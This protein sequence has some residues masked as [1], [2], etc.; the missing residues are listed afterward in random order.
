MAL[1]LHGKFDRSGVFEC[2]CH[3]PSQAVT[4]A[5]RL[6]ADVVEVG[7]QRL[8]KQG[9]WV[10]NDEKVIWPNFLKAQTCRRSDKVRQAESRRNRR[11]NSL[12]PLDSL[13]HTE[14]PPVTTVV[15]PSHQPSPQV[16]LSLAKLSLAEG[17][18]A[19]ARDPDPTPPD[20]VVLLTDRTG[21]TRDHFGESF[22]SSH[23]DDIAVFDAWAKAFGKQARF[24]SQRSACLGERRRA[25]MSTQDGFDAILG[26]KADDYVNGK[27]DG[28]PH[29]QIRFI[30]GDQERFEE[31]R[32]SGRRA[33]TKNS[34]CS[35]EDASRR[36]LA[37]EA[38]AQAQ[39][40]AE[41]AQRAREAAR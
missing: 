38:K 15:T 30:F 33:R 23:P 10:I 41:R 18:S 11:E 8:L 39:V 5:T 36:A 34:D 14:S 2:G 35:A 28:R 6:P 16:T 1:M 40:T 17:E 7:L 27:K 13:S 9:T 19:Q 37:V 25:G 4:L 24:D 21:T 31:F 32:D 3:T 22:Q 12:T 26:A 29:D 20:P